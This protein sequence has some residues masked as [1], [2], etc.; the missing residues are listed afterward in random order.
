MNK[1][2]VFKSIEGRDQIRAI[3]FLSKELLLCK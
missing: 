1:V 2:S 3:P